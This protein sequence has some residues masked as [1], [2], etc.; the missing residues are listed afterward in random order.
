MARP[1]EPI[2][3]E[4]FDPW[5]VKKLTGNAIRMPHPWAQKVV[6]DGSTNHGFINKFLKDTVEDSGGIHNIGSKTSGNSSDY[7]DVVPKP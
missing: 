3:N 1:F 5:I 6:A 4:S 7:L 2:D